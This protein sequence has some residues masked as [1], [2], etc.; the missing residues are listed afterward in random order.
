MEGDIIMHTTP[1]ENEP[2]TPVGTTPE[3]TDPPHKA[4]KFDAGT[5]QGTLDEMPSG[6]T[7]DRPV[8]DGST[9]SSTAQ[10]ETDNPF[11]GMADPALGEF[12]RGGSATP[13]PPSRP[14]EQ[15]GDDDANNDD[16]DPTVD[17]DADGTG[18]EKNHGELPRHRG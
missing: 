18:N 10:R 9:E 15:H 6:D 7:L 1:D 16:V 5:G 3:L 2:S 17:D 8:L 13:L 12:A 4:T 11:R 14:E